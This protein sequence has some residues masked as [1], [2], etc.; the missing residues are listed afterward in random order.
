MRFSRFLL[1][2]SEARILARVARE[3]VLQLKLYA[4]PER[5]V[6]KKLAASLANVQSAHF[7]F[8]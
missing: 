6:A 5:I 4:T 2:S 1:P 7:I 8:A 3:T